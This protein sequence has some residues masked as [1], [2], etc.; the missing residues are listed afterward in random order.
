[1]RYE[2][3]IGTGFNRWTKGFYTPGQI[4]AL[5][6]YD[7]SFLLCS[8]SYRSGKSEG[9]AR[10]ALRH[11]YYFP[12]SKSGLFRAFLASLKKS[13][14]LTV[15]ELTHPS[16]VANWSNTDLVLEL[17]NGSSV[18]FVGADKPDRIG[19]TEYT[20]C[21]VDEATEVREESLGMIQGRLSGFLSLPNNLL[22]L[23]NNIQDYLK[24]TLDKRQLFLACNPKSSSHFLYPKF[25]GSPQPY[26]VHY[27]SNSISNPNLP[28]SYLVNNLSNYLLPGHDS[29]WIEEQIQQIRRGEK[30]A[31]G[32]HLA[33][34]LNALG[35]RNLLGLWVALEGAI[36]DLDKDKNTIS[37]IPETWQPYYEGIYGA[38]DYGFHNPR[39]GLFK[40]FK[41]PDK[42]TYV[43]IDG[44]SESG[45]TSEDF[46][47]MLAAKR[48]QYTDLKHVYFPHDRPDILK[49]AKRS[50]GS[51][52][53]KKAKINVNPGIATVSRFF[54]NNQIF[55]LRT[56]KDFELA[57]SELTG[58]QWKKDKEG[59]ALEEPVKDKD[60]YPDVFRY[61]LHSLHHK[62]SFKVTETTERPLY[63]AY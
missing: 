39:L 6:D 52:F 25:I 32:L 11:A 42:Q 40:S 19:S 16:W 27:I 24:S 30:G 7:N 28:V 29:Y 4:K 34:A 41:L 48:S 8:G 62:D 20:F 53:V 15:L 33:D 46:V 17:K 47:A 63:T 12:R 59:N 60:H 3:K 38:V 21:G 44:W 9:M 56:A 18:H 36:Y 22:S 35:K 2:S 54:N 13:T 55:L 61:L 50:L 10:A 5:H 1:M 51:S 45:G 31:D 49:S 26:H 14:M 57:W 37:S 43:Y 58:Y 23:P